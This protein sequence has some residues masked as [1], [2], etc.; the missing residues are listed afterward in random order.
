MHVYS[1][2]G[3]RELTVIY[4]IGGPAFSIISQ[5]KVFGHGRMCQ[6]TGLYG[7]W[8]LEDWKWNA[9]TVLQT[10][11]NKQMEWGQGKNGK[12]SAPIQGL[13]VTC[14][15]CSLGCQTNISSN[16]P[17]IINCLNKRWSYDVTDISTC[18]RKL[19]WFCQSMTKESE[20]KKGRNR[21]AY[22]HCKGC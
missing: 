7:I 2:I 4:N 13:G 3:A 19:N 8:L 18:R 5:H 9:V 20:V 22:R 16:A 10:G 11:E 1:N 17:D 15:K 6:K 21:L 12:F 14:Y